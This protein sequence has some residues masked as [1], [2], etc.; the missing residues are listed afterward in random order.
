MKKNVLV[1]TVLLA[2]ASLSAAS[3][4]VIAQPGGGYYVYE[5]IYYSDASRTV[6][7]GYYFDRCDAPAEGG[8][9]VTPYYH[10]TAVGYFS[11]TQGCTMY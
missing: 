8:G 5:T 7:V 4:P 3:A 10:R 11:Y 1:W 6:Q 9:D 2:V